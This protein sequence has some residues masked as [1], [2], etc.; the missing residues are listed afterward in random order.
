MNLNDSSSVPGED[1]VALPE[2]W[3]EHTLDRRGRRE[4]RPVVVDADA[5]QRLQDLFGK[6]E[7]NLQAPLEAAA[8]QGGPL[9]AL[10]KAGLA[11]EPDPEAAAFAVSLLMRMHW[12]RGGEI[13]LT[14]LHAWISRH[15]LAFATEALMELFANSLSW[16]RAKDHPTGSVLSFGPHSTYSFA[17]SAITSYPALADLRSLL[18]ALPDGEYEALRDR[19]AARRTSEAHQAVGAVLMPDQEQWVRDACTVFASRSRHG[20][21]IIWTFISTAEH[22]EL[23]GVEYLDHPQFDASAI[24]LAVDVLGTEA[25][26]VLTA[27]LDAESKPGAEARDL[28]FEAIGRLPSDAAVAYLLERTVRPQALTALRQAAA[29]FPVRTLRAAAAVAPTA[30]LPARARIA[31]LLREF[32]IEDRMSAL[33]DAQR[34]SVEEL[35]AAAAR[36]PVAE[37]PPAVFAVPPWAPFGK[38]GKTAVAGLVPPEINELR[39]A[40]EEQ[41]Q[42]G[43]MPEEGYAYEY[44]RGNPDMWE[45]M[46]PQGPDPDHYY[47]PELLAWGP[48][49]RARAALPLWAGKFEWSTTET[50]CAILARF[51]D[52]AAAQVMDLVK[53]R[54]SQRAAMMPFLSLD[55]ARL[56]A[57]LVSRPRGDR[58]LGRAWLDRHAAD[59]ASLLIPDALGKAGKP[60][61]RAIDALKHLAA[62]DRALLDERAAAYGQAALEAVAAIV[63]ADPLDPQRRVPKAP[64]WA[65]PA[66]LPPVLLAGREAALPAD[67]VRTLMSAVALDD[68][69][70]LYPGAE[71]LV[72]EC[73]PAS[74]TAFSWGLFELWLSAGSPSK[75]GWAMDQLRRFADDVAV[76]RLTDLIREWP[77]QSQNRKAVRGLEILGHIGS[78]AA[79]RSVQAIA[80][81]AKFKALKKTAA[82]Q[83]EVIAER[84]DLSLDQLADRLV[85]DFG[86]SSDAPLVLDYGPRSFTVKFDEGLKPFVLDDKGKRR[87]SAPKPAA[88]DDAELAQAGF[89]RFA[90]L[91]KELK[92]AATAQVKRLETAMTGQR[93][94]TVPEFRQYLV[95]HPVAWQLTS[96]LVWQCSDGDGWR[97]FRLAEDRTAADAED[98]PFDLPE[99]ASVR[100]GHPVTLGAEVAAWAEVFADYEI[101]Q[102]FEQ[103]TRLVLTLTD[104]EREAGRVARFE[105]AKTG[106]GPLIGLLKRGWKY[107]D[108]RV[109]SYGRGIYYEFPEGGFVLLESSPGVHPGYGY[110]DNE[111]VLEKVIVALPEEGDV[112]PVRMSETLTVAARIARATR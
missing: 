51:G 4:P 73:D 86:L 67:G 104:E 61:L 31:G 65:D 72:A 79:L 20:A 57:D 54:P 22:L 35:L 64:A 106:A 105:G 74:L 46:M 18:A 56:A 1:A 17:R 68:P 11:H 55:A 45:R 76:R 5:P 47:F 24:A 100:I 92:A 30:S 77:G 36:Y 107:G 75:D 59:A 39:W 10:L 49:D 63:D 16:Y 70:L 66:M 53:K 12:Q 87:A 60:R 62:T 111:Q 80:S 82:A 3:T 89:E 33:D 112:D 25:L 37:E 93:E 88:A 94:W 13:G 40:P 14:A 21:K 42:W 83:I 15:G 78:E 19:V 71:P 41:E 7:L 48:E 103:L 98:E 97:S 101:L 34:A 69:D 50:L 27:T 108:P 32:G 85:P 99:D 95:D 29:R 28:M 58:A 23:C 26:P 84:L 9:E 6:N 109:R 102:P 110:D 96:R 81:N 44:I 8:A 2:S 52:E 43:T 91:R 38:A 90:L